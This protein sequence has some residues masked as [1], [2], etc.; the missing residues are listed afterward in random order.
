VV[1]FAN[2]ADGRIY[3]QPRGGEPT[4]I[5]TPGPLRYADLT[6]DAAADRLLCVVE[7]H[8]QPAV[9]V[10]AD[11]AHA[12]EPANYLAAID[13]RSGA[14]TRLAHGYDFY[15]TPRPSPDGRW[16]AWL[17]WRHPNMPWDSSELW[18]AELDADGRPQAARRVSGGNDVSIVQPEWAP[19]GALV[20]ASDE[21]GWWNLYRLEVGVDRPPRPLAAMEAEFAGPQW[22]FGLSWYAVDDDG[23]ILAISRRGG[24][25][26]LWRLPVDGS[27]AAIEVGQTEMGDIRAGGGRAVIVGASPTTAQAVILLDLASGEQHVL[28]RT[29]E[30]EIDPAYVA[31]P[32]P[33]SFPTSGG[34]TA[35][36]LFYRPT[37]PGVRPPAGE[38]PPLVVM[39]HGGPTSNAW[40]GLSLESSSSPAAVSPSSTST[41][42]GAP[43]TAA[44][45]CA[46]WT[47]S[48]ASSTWTIA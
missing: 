46:G 4:P 6:Y 42:V 7:D 32:E 30:L 2:L 12:A 15:S 25:D 36:A 26:E 47:A 24:R 34:R 40:G 1:Y 21:G 11:G 3:G 20:Y 5:T 29:A 44:S 33:I 13:P 9:A 8:G 18:L 48:G 37:N 28:R 38:R 14:I 27:P 16:L 17:C 43:A 22:V 23:T 31:V 45:T 41:T 39:I 35:H 19:E 10:A